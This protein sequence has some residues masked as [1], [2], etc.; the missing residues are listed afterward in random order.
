MQICL[1]SG[2]MG[3]GKT[4]L[5]KAL[6][7]YWREKRGACVVVNFADVLYDMHDAVLNVLHEHWPNRNLAKDGPLLQM[8][9]TDW[10]RNTIDKDIWVK[11]LQ[12]RVRKFSAGTL[13]IV[14]DC[15][16]V[17]EIEAF[18]YALHVRLEASREVRRARCSMWRENDTHASEIGL[19]DQARAGLF[20]IYLNTETTDVAGCV[21]LLTVALDKGDW[22]NRRKK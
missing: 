18:P 3:S 2:K 12:E 19:D 8:L 16:F 1:L 14:G 10:G 11:I 5:Q 17:N 6:S 4:S 9:G 15:R 7:A 20:D 22:I 21:S 13:V